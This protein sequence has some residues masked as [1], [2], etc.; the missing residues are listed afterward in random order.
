MEMCKKKSGDGEGKTCIGS[1]TVCIRIKLDEYGISFFNKARIIL[2]AIHGKK[3]MNIP[4][5]NVKPDP[6]Q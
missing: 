3:F 6:I 2:L 4:L 5:V 1:Y